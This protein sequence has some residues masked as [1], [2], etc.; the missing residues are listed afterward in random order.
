LPRVARPDALTAAEASF[1]SERRRRVLIVDDNADAADSLAMLLK[2]HGHET[3]VAYSAK[4]ALAHLE[5]FKPDVGLLDIGLPQMDGYELSKQLR[6]MPQL[7][8]LRLIALTGYGQLEDRQRARAAGF[9][10]HLVKP[11]DLPALERAFAG[12]PP[13][14]SFG[15]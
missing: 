2:F 3:Y 1:K 7:S 14:G 4:E 15:S 13:G 10:D 6:A 12:I 9:D 11:V 5:S 8:A